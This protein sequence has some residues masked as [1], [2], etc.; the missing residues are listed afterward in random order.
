MENISK[1]KKIV[2][3]GCTG[4]LGFQVT[5][6]F[7][8]YKFFKIT[9]TFQ[10]QKSLKVL[11]KKLN[12]RILKKIKFVKF[13]AANFTSSELKKILKGNGYAVNCIGII[14][15]YIDEKN[16]KA[17]LALKVNSI[18]PHI[19]NEINNK[20]NLKIYQ[21]AT[22]CVF[23][24]KAG[25]YSETCEHDMIDVY[26]RTKSLGEVVDKN[27]FNLRCSIIGSEIKNYSSLF[28][29]FKKQKKNVTIKGFEDHI[30][31]G[32]TTNVFAELIKGIIINDI[33]LPN[34]IHLVP[35]KNINKF[36]LLTKF[37]KILKRNDITI[38]RSKS[39][40]SI[41]RTLKT[42]YTDLN[43]KIWNKSKFKKCLNISDVVNK[44]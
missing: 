29:W 9:A 8:Q 11:K 6:V 36:N 16:K 5:K 15:P 18:F 12:N 14:K 22:D 35:K 10:N 26:G 1:I 23:K 19:L 34:L 4:M 38:V 43:K 41:D 2:I 39:N 3:F 24:G 17:I 32:L 30:W 7:S 40:I 27:F 25:L 13:D 33:K 44:I 21:I 28:E 31:N 20:F 42:L 37:K